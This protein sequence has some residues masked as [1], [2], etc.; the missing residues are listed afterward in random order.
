MT[1]SRRRLGLQPN[2]LDN[3]SNNNNQFWVLRTL[4]FGQR[5]RIKPTM[6]VGRV[7]ILGPHHREERS[8]EIMGRRET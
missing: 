3:N 2:L 5:K 4:L 6:E 1:S 8:E 7:P